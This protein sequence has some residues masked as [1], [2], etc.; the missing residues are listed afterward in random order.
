MLLV[1]AILLTVSKQAE[2][3]LGFGIGLAAPLSGRNIA[4]D[5]ELFG[6]GIVHVTQRLDASPQLLG[7][8][9]YAFKINDK[10]GVGP[11]MGF[12]PRVDFGSASSLEKESPVSAGFGMVVQ[13][14]MGS[15]KQKLNFG[16]MWA[17]S[18]PIDQVGDL[19][20]DGFQAPRT[21]QDI[22]IVP[23]IEHKSVSRVM[24]TMSVSGIF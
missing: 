17:I 21:L 19:W 24:F 20:Q 9:H 12:M 5:A 14:G 8:F 7:E 1:F 16:I 3:Q 2:A 15:R 10:V 11:A 23:Q 22:P 18:V 6:G 13:C 4:T